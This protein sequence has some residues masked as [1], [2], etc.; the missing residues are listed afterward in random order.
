[1]ELN[2]VLQ[3]AGSGFSSFSEFSKTISQ[4]VTMAGDQWHSGCERAPRWVGKGKAQGPVQTSARRA[5]TVLFSDSA[6]CAASL[7][8]VDLPLQIKLGLVRILCRC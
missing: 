2:D 4:I 1:M 5:H 7:P 8:Y 6:D 3:E